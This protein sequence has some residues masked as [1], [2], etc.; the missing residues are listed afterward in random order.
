MSV[1]IPSMSPD[2]EPGR[3]RCSGQR[4]RRLSRVSTVTRD[5]GWGQRVHRSGGYGLGLAIVRAIA[6]AHA[7][8]AT[9]FAREGGGLDIAVAFPSAD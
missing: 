4:A 8:S 3:Q 6:E 9:A 5:G 1:V 2:L 7:A